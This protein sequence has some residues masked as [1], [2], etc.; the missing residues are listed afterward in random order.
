VGGD[1]SEEKLMTAA[2]RLPDKRD[3]TVEDLASLPEVLRYELI[4]GRLVLPSPTP[5]QRVLGYQLATMLRPNCPATY[6]PVPDLSL[7]IDCRSELRPD[8]VVVHERYMTRSPVPIDGAMLVV[9]IISPTSRFQDMYAKT[10][11][12]A[13]AR[14]D[15]YW[16]VDPTFEEGVELTIFRP[17]RSGEYEMTLSTNKALDTDLPYPIT[18]DVPALTAL[19]D[20]YLAARDDA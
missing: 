16:V 1:P 5:F 20:K 2:L 10:R 18:I 9:E 12:Y 4:D 17:G 13:A 14:V 3:W 15:D 8:V 19:R 7:D 6:V 11:V